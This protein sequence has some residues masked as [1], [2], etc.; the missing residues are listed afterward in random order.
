PGKMTSACRVVSLSHRSTEIIASSVGNA[1]SSLWPAGVDSTGFPATVISALIWPSR[2]VEI[3]SARH[4]TGTWPRTSLA[5]RTLV[6]Y[7]PNSGAPSSSPGIGCTVTDHAVGSGNMLPPG[8]SKWR[9]R[10]LTTYE[11]ASQAAEF[12]I[13]GADAAVHHCTFRAGKLARQRADPV[14]V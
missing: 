2:G 11:P 8:T 5:P 12:L 9:V 3:S 4:D 7:R 13:T 1:S 6:R 10:M 14:G